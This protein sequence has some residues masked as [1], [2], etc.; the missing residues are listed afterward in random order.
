M[1]KLQEQVDNL[2]SQQESS[3]ISSGSKMETE[4]VEQE[5]DGLIDVSEATQAFLWEAFSAVMDNEDR[6]KR[7]K[8]IGVPNCN[9]ICCPK[10]DGVIKAVLPTDAIK[11]DGYLP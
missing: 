2:Q 3:G 7:V 11:A 10:L 5:P 1:N 9:Q 6:E 4:E 8:R